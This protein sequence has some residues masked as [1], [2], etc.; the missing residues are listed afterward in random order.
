MALLLCS[1]LF[2]FSKFLNFD[3]AHVY[4]CDS[5]AAWAR[6][7]FPALIQTYVVPV[8]GAHVCVDMCGHARA[9]EGY[10]NAMTDNVKRGLKTNSRNER[11]QGGYEMVLDDDDIAA[12]AASGANNVALGGGGGGGG[13]GHRGGGERDH[14]R[15]RDRRDRGDRGERGRDRDRDRDRDRER[16]KEDDRGK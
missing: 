5:R 10:A 14:D 9:R 15:D 4:A 2:L 13:R 8:L 7:C 3:R 12:T 11:K 1:A 16:P 6:R